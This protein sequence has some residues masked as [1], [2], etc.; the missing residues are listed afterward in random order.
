MTLDFTLKKN[1]YLLVVLGDFNAKL[2]Q[3]YD[4]DNSTSEGILIENI[5]SQFGLH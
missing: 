3:W 4:K 5:T 1:P 2:R